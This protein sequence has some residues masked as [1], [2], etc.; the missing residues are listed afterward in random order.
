MEVG[1]LR[2]LG[3]CVSG[4]VGV[5]LANATALPAPAEGVADKTGRRERAGGERGTE[6]LGARGRL[7]PLFILPP[8]R[9][10]V[11]TNK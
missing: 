8:F 5:F 10:G 6:D 9:S 7:P 2:G 1:A 3:V 11:Q 4:V